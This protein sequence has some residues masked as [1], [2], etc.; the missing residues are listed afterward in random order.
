MKLFEKP[1]GFIVFCI[2]LN[3]IINLCNRDMRKAN[4][5]IDSRFHFLLAFLY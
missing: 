5:K 4:F 2:V 3:K 1:D